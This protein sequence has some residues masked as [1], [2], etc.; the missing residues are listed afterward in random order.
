MTPA[1]ASPQHRLAVGKAWIDF[2]LVLGLLVLYLLLQTRIPQ[3]DAGEWEQYIDSGRL[4]INQNYILLVPTLSAIKWAGAQLGIQLAA[5]DWLQTANAVCA[6]LML[7][8]FSSSLRA[9][10]TRVGIRVA[11]LLLAGLSYNIVYLATSDHAKLLTGPFLALAAHNLLVYGKSLRMRDIAKAGLWFGWSSAFLINSILCIPSIAACLLLWAPQGRLRALKHA[12]VFA[13]LGCLVPL[14]A[15]LAFYVQSNTDLTYLRWMSSYGRGGAAAVDAGIQPVTLMS[16]LRAP[17]ALVNNFADASTLGPAL[18][19]FITRTPTAAPQLHSTMDV[20]RA[21]GALLVG[22]GIAGLLFSLPRVWRGANQSVR[23]G[24]A[25]ALTMLLTFGLFALAWNSSEEEYWFQTTLPLALL[26]A[27]AAQRLSKHTM[28][29]TGIAV[30]LAVM[31][32]NNIFGYA[33]ARRLVPYEDMLKVAAQAFPAHSYVLTDGVGPSVF[34][35]SQSH[36]NLNGS[37]RIVD[38]LTLANHVGKSPATVEAAVRK[39]AAQA[40][41]SG[42]CVY[43]VGIFDANPL[44]HPWTL[45]SE[46]TAITPAT[47]AAG[48]NVGT[49]ERVARRFYDVDVWAVND[50]RPD[51]H[52][53]CVEPLRVMDQLKRMTVRQIF[54]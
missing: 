25:T 52:A 28:V 14:A 10:A 47:F 5:F 20:L 19:S 43:A 42:G 48:L 11:C 23:F 21:A 38:G 54:P 40:L 6:A 26:L 32:V 17:F 12:G 7:G 30:A 41:Q 3:G 16:L 9:Y 37:W 8:I 27:L 46:R 18:K 49:G 31:L 33:L 50:Q 1:P 2:G 24:L 22:L 39:D 44:Q 35:I 51:W 53:K 45:L 4:F 34:A 15:T 36:S 13:L 29:A